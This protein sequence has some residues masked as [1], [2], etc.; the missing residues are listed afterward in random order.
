[1]HKSG[2]INKNIEKLKIELKQIR[3][4]ETIDTSQMTDGNPL[5][6]L[7]IIHYAFLSYS[8]Y[9]AQYLF[10]NEYELFSLNIGTPV[11]LFYRVDSS[12]QYKKRIKTKPLSV[13]KLSE[14]K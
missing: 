5:I 1:M 6:F 9:V 3:Y 11:I 14:K 12:L 4:P 8:K 7:P 2:D 10:D 13:Q